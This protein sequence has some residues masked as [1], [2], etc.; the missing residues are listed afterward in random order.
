M[1]R[2]LLLPFLLL[3]TVSA[4]HLEN[5]APHLESLETQADLGQDLD[6]SK[7][8]ERDLALTEEVIQAE[9]EEV[10]ASACQDNFE[11]EEAMESDPAAL[12]KDFQCPR[13]EDIV[14]VQGSPRCKTC[15][16][17]LVRTPK[18]FA[19]AQNVCSRC[20]GGNLVSIHDFNFNYRIQCCT[21]TV[22]QAQVW[23]G[24]NL[25]GWFLW[26]RFCWTDGSH[27]NFAYWSP[28][29]PGNGQGSCVALCTKGG[30]WRRAQCDKQLPF[31]CSF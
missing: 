8:Q 11:D 30:Y 27:W 16:Y 1:Q 25:R 19:E 31:V 28:G 7:E 15:R 18:T 6:S 12:D 5:D 3:G 24:G 22:N 10:K 9:G 13:E 20:Y 17:L 2:L 4:L 29:Q 23:I 14:E 21:S 26:K